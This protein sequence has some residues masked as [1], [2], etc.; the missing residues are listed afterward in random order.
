MIKT[1]IV[2]DEPLARK[3]INQLLE[4]EP[5]FEIVA[6]CED[7]LTAVQKIDDIKPDLVFLDIQMPE[8]DGFEVL[9]NL[10]I[11]PMPL[12]IFI[13]AYDEFALNAFRANAVDYLTK[14]I[15][16]LHFKKAV[17][18]VRLLVQAKSEPDYISRVQNMLRDVQ[19]RPDFARRFLVKE[20]N[21]ILIVPVEKINIF[22]AAGDYVTLH[23]SS[24][25]H[26]IRETLTN[27]EQK[28]DPAVFIRI[29]RSAIIRISFISELEPLAKGDYLLKLSSG[30][31][32]TLSRNYREQVLNTL[33]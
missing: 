6:E 9:S 14:P 31:Q 23:T 12:I 26:L 13:T 20:K 8:L 3:G 10:N 16:E 5:D 29:N 18:R 33:N 7:G 25:K 17:A 11:N 15:D 19:S 28:L 1:I 24:S 21:K 4:N 30:Q 32:F 2:D 27:V 22:E